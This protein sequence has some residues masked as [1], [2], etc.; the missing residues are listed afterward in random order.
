VSKYALCE[1]VTASPISPWHIRKL[2]ERGLRPGGGADTPALCGACVRWDLESP[3]DNH[4]HE[5]Y[6]CVKCRVE[7]LKQEAQT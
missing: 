5:D 4:V 6:V 7:Y 2:T 3:V 1:R